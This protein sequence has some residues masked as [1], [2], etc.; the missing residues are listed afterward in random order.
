V[1]RDDEYYI[2]QFAVQSKRDGDPLRQFAERRRL[3]VRRDPDDGTD[4]VVGRRGHIYE[5]SEN[6]LGVMF[7]PPKTENKPW[8]K[9]MP[10][11]WGQLQ[12]SRHCHRHD[13]ETER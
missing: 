11:T 7:M 6:E 10:R 8:G 3:K 5:Y 12:T 4:I 1:K 13:G 9:W 2:N